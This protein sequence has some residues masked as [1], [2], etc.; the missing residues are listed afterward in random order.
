MHHQF[1]VSSLCQ[2]SRTK[3]HTVEP[4]ISLEK[5]HEIVICT[6]ATIFFQ[7]APALHLEK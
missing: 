2:F 1:S 5:P 4:I 7:V 6:V 3:K